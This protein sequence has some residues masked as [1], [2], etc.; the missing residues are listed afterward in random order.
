MRKMRIAAV[1]D[2]H[3]RPTGEDRPLVDAIRARVQDIDPD[4]FII[5]GDISDRL[6]V[7]S[8]TLSSLRLTGAT[9]LYV[10]GNHDIWFEKD[11]G[12]G[13][14]E[15][16]SKA[17]GAACQQNGFVHLPDGAWIHDDLA[18]VGSIGWSDYSFR[19]AELGIPLTCYEA[20]EY[21]GATWYDVFNVDWEF[22][23]VEATDLFNRKLQYDL[24]TLGPTVKRIVYVSHHLPFREL[25]LYKNRLPW[26]F[27]SAFMGAQSTGEIVAADGRVVLSISGHSHVRNV[28]DQGQ[29]KAITVPLGYGRPLDAQYDRL[30]HDAV[31]HIELLPDRTELVDFR[32]GDICDGLPYYSVDQMEP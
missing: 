19:R 27:F 3:I 24:S 12:L 25:T 22:T 18:F 26:D 32:T 8:D 6:S 4:V 16:Y 5:A 30:A 29:I 28:I 11:S 20:K 23:D 17:I 1:S 31:A 7:L 21:R 2:L 10:A 15:K 13:S 9:C 14:L